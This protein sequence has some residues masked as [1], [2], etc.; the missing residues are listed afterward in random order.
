[1]RPF[2]SYRQ[3]SLFIMRPLFAYRAKQPLHNEA[4][5]RERSD[6]GRFL[7]IGPKQLFIMKPF[8][9]Y[10]AKKPLHTGVRTGCH[11]LISL[12]C[13]YPSVYICATFV[14]FTDYESC[15]TPIFHKPGI[16]GSGRVWV[17]AWDVFRRTPSRGGRSCRAAVDFWCVLGAA[18][19]RV[20][21]FE[22]TRL[23]LL[24]V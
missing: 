19:I 12:V 4:R 6:R 23:V 17:N 24:E 11:Y 20:F 18:G 7:P 3:K 10:R 14:V 16:Y 8:F 2:F 15:T 1:M 22:R 9:A 5:L 13:L 21:F